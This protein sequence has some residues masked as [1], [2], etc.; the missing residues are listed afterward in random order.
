MGIDVFKKGIIN[1]TARSYQRQVKS[2]YQG[3]K[4]YESIK[5]NHLT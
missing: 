5:T 4:V 2:G 1:G 3:N